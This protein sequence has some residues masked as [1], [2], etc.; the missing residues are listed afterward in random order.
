MLSIKNVSKY[1]DKFKAIDNINIEV[2]DG[3]IHGLIGENGAG[4]T[5]LIHCIAGIYKSNEGE[6][7]LDGETIYDNPYVK[8][9]IG[10]VADSNQYFP[11]FKIKEL[12][13]FYK[14]IYKNF[15]EEKFYN[16]NELFNLDVNKKVKQISKGMQM[17]LSLM[18]NLSINP[19]L[20]VLDEPTSGLDVISKKHIMDLLIQEVEQ[21]NCSIV[22]SSHH[23]SELELLCD[24]ISFIQNGKIIHQNSV[25]GI[26]NNI[27]KYQVVFDNTPNLNTLKDVLNVENI[28]CVYYIIANRDSNIKEQIKA[29]SPQIIE[30]VG[31]SLEEVFIYTSIKK[32]G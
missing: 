5:T 20:L 10:Y 9:Q 16:L 17:R 15:D 22:I 11:D 12:V 26:K 1:Y 21:R 2:E 30:E 7:T 13:K 25:D 4:K 8:E 19:K 3:K 24:D 28:G 27:I 14:G 31:M 29:L 32:E 23:L 6:I 18:L